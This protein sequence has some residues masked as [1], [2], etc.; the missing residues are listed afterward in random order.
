M[1]WK[2]CSELIIKPGISPIVLPIVYK[3]YQSKSKKHL[4]Q[5]QTTSKTN[6]TN[7]SQ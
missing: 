1:I 7:T 5:K 6:T 3:P 2:Y 4:F